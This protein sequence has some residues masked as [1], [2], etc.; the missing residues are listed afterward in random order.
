[1]TIVLNPFTNEEIEFT[2]D[3]PDSYGFEVRIWNN[4]S[5][6]TYDPTLTIVVYPAKTNPEGTKIDLTLFDI[7]NANLLNKFP[8]Y[9][10]RAQNLCGLQTVSMCY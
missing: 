9:F 8:L 1:M 3:Y 4:P 7:A 2:P 5:K 10:L 6:T